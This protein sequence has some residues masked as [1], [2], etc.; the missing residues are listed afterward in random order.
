MDAGNRP[1]LTEALG[2]SA[3]ELA[4]NRAGELSD[5]QLARLRE[6]HVRQRGRSG[7]RT[8]T[9]AV[10]TAIV[11]V[12]AAAAGLPHL[13]GSHGKSSAEVPILVAAVILV[14]LLMWRSVA[15][16]RDSAG[17]LAGGVLSEAEGVAK[18]RRHLTAGGAAADP[19]AAAG[20][21]REPR[22]ELSIGGT[23]FLVTPS[24]LA[25]FTDGRAYRAYYVGQGPRAMIVSAEQI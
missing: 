9:A 23:R 4:A 25:A 8:R 7:T 14:A 19:V 16:A 12:L 6:A 17:R 10:T 15:R 22:C 11:V 20:P 13:T 21:A 1:P 18:T 24:V 2:F 3:W 5:R